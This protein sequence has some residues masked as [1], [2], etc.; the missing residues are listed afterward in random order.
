M[1]RLNTCHGVLSIRANC[2]RL[3]VTLLELIVVLTIIG[4]G[5]ALLLPAMQRARERAQ[6]KRRVATT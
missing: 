5:L 4:V 1:R 3:G 2:L 6:E